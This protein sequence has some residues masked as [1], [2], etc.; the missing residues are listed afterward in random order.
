[1]KTWFRMEVAAA[2]PTVADIYVY[3]IIGGW[4]DDLYASWGID[5]GTTA[6]TFLDQL[7]KL[8]ASIKTINVHINSPGGDVFSAAAIANALRGESAKGRQVTSFVEGLA[9]SAASVLMMGAETIVVA[10]NALV[11]VHNPWS[12]LCGN[13]AEMRKAADEL[14]KIRDSIVA[15]YRWHSALDADAIIALMNGETW[16]DADEAIANGFATSKVEGLKAAALIAPSALAK[17]SIP[18]KFKDRVAALV[19]AP[20]TEAQ[21]A[22]AAAALDVIRACAAAG[23]P[24]L[25]EELVASGATIAQVSARVAEVKAQRQ[26]ELTRVAN[27]R[28]LC[29]TAK[30]PELAD[31]YVRGGMPADEVRAQLAIVTAKVDNKEID[32]RLGPDL[33]GRR[34][35]ALNPAEIYAARNRQT[36]P[37]E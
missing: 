7:S 1:M 15:S 23:C 20:K 36:T 13:A 37:K 31:G 30:C 17:L 8:D 29:D 12:C 32:G 18:E 28:A 25:S 14:D 4:I 19:A 34:A 5:P 10:D 27:I 2:N 26:T 22:T 9:A 33:G 16:M 24:D 3:D 6:K 35:E 11:M 21:P